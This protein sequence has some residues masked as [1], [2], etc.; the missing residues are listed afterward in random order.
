[1][2][3]LVVLNRLLFATAVFDQTHRGKK[4]E[5]DFHTLST[6]V[7]NGSEFDCNLCENN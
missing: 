2:C 4:I 7:V 3:V 5:T 6:G 1:V